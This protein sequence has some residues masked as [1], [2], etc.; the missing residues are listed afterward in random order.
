M[1]IGERIREQRKLK[2]LTQS[3]LA[4]LS[5]IATITVNQYE[6][7]KRQPSVKQLHKL[8]RALDVP[9]S[10]FVEMSSSVMQDTIAQAVAEELKSMGIPQEYADV[11]QAVVNKGF[12]MKPSKL[13]EIENSFAGNEIASLMEYMSVIAKAKSEGTTPNEL[14]E[15]MD[16]KQ[17]IKGD[18]KDKA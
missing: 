5:G 11:F 4:E 13:D 17:R 2:K 9:I 6:N 8:A 3:R 14:R 1:N 7:G 10:L 12:E 18:T 16:F 15:Y